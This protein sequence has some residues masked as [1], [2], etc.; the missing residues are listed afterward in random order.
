[1]SLAVLE[2]PRLRLW[3]LDADRADD[4]EFN[5]RLLN[6]EGYLRNIGDRGVRTLAQSRAYL[7]ERTVASYALHGFGLYRMEAKD[8]GDDVGVCGLLKRDGIDDVEI[9]YALLPAFR[10]RGYAREAAIAVMRHARQS[11]G[12]TRLAAIVSPH[13]AASIRLL[14]KLGMQYRK[15]VQL[16]DKSDAVKL[17]SCVLN[18]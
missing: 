13:N 18:S 4:V 14:E 8:G 16:P 3:R 1:M 15:T 17:F 6:D 7:L 9:G 10:R 12:L 2:T 11:H 5:L